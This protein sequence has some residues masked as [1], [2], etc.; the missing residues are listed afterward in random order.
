MQK[1]LNSD[2]LLAGEVLCDDLK[3]RRRNPDILLD[4]N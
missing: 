1:T 2:V 4:R 3:K